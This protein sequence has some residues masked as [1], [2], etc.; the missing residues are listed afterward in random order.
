MVIVYRAVFILGFVISLISCGSGGSDTS[1]YNDERSNS[2]WPPSTLN[3]APDTFGVIVDS[4]V[5]GL[6]YVSGE[7]YGIT[8]DVGRWLSRRPGGSILYR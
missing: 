2:N 6:R 1:G 5:A 8:D 3:K 7:H 4:P